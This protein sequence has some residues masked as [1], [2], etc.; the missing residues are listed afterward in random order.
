M[1]DIASPGVGFGG[2]AGRTAAV[3]GAAQGIGRAVADALLAGGAQVALLDIRPPD[4]QQALDQADNTMFVECDVTSESSVDAAFSLVESTWGGVDILVNNAGIFAIQPLE[5]TDLDDWNRMMAVN[6]TGCFL[7]S[8]RALPQMRERQWGRIISIGS[9]AGKTG[10]SK[11]TAA[12]GA[13]KAGVMALAKAIAT[14]YAP[15]GITSNALA[16][17]LIDTDMVAGIADLA[18]RI[19]V[20]RLGRPTDVAQAVLFLAGD[21]AEFITGEVM[22]VNGGF[23]ID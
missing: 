23:L 15:W 22:D 12:Y 7:C 1:T 16:P 5:E 17:A 3:T 14:E 10:G 6:L 18:D 19:P 13:S 9:S 8:R 2:V 21:Q 11:N 20:G 4:D